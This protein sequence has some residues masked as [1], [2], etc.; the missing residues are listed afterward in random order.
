[1]RGMVRWLE[2]I[3]ESGEQRAR[4][5]L[6]SSRDFADLTPTQYGEALEWIRRLSLHQMLPTGKMRILETILSNVVPAWLPDADVLIQSVDEL[7]EDVLG[8]SLALE[9]DSTQALASIR[10][11]SGKVN[12]ERRAQ[13]GRT[14]ESEA[15][16]LVSSVPQIEVEHVAVF[17][18]SFGYDIEVNV[19]GSTFHLEVK[20]TVRENRKLIY[21][22]RNEFETSLVDSTW[23]LILLTLGPNGNATGIYS[24]DRDWLEKLAPR[25]C[26]PEAH[27]Q[28]ARYEVPSDAITRGIPELLPYC[29][30]STSPL[31]TGA[32]RR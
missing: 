20:A 22:S 25:D 9:L 26:G 29:D 1:M 28:S 4:A 32:W 18:D 23:R 30:G 24:V 17:D 11:A 2:L 19:G 14:G 21:L 5:I 12:L 6:E 10:R 16:R 8:V 31:V 15:V 3:P 7:P 27:W 13:I